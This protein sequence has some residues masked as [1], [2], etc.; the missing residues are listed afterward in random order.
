MKQNKT[1]F[2]ILI[3]CIGNPL[4]RR[5]GNL[6]LLSFVAAL[7]FTLVYPV[8]DLLI[9]KIGYYLEKE[10]YST[11]KYAVGVSLVVLLAW[12]LHQMGG[13]RIRDFYTFR[14][15][16]SIWKLAIITAVVWL[17]FVNKFIIGYEYSITG[18][19][20]IIL[21]VLALLPFIN[22]P[23]ARILYLRSKFVSHR[24]SLGK[25]TLQQKNMEDSESFDE[26]IGWL[27]EEKPIEKPAEDRFGMAVVA[28]RVARILREK[29]LKTIGLIGSYGCGKSSILNMVE[30]YIK[31]PPQG[32]NK[33]LFDQNKIIICK[34]DGWGLCKDSAAEVILRKTVAELSKYVD[35]LGL[36]NIPQEYQKALSDAGSWW[37]KLISIGFK[38]KDAAKQLEKLDNVLLRTGMR[39]IIFI[40]D[41]DRNVQKDEKINEVAALLDRLKGLENVSFVLAISSNVNMADAGISMRLAEHIEVIPELPP[42]FVRTIIGTFRKNRLSQYPDDIDCVSKD[43]RDKQW[44]PE[45]ILP[46]DLDVLHSETGGRDR[47]VF[48]IPKLL[49]GPRL[50][51]QSL[52]RTWQAWQN[53]RGE[54]DFDDLLMVNVLRF[55][56]PEAFDFVHNYIYKLR[57]AEGGKI[58]NVIEKRVGAAC[59]SMNMGGKSDSGPDMKVLWDNNVKDI[60]W[61]IA[62]AYNLIE[63]IFPGITNWDTNKTLG[64]QCIGRES[65]S[66]DYWVRLN[67]EEL[68]NN[69]IQDQQILL[70]IDKWKQ[71]KESNVHQ[72]HTLAEA[73]LNVEGFAEK[74]EQFGCQLNGQ[75]LKELAQQYFDLIRDEAKQS[76]NINHSEKGTD[77]GFLALSNLI[78]KYGGKDL[79][80]EWVKDEIANTLPVSLELANDIHR[81]YYEVFYRLSQKPQEHMNYIVKKAEEIYED[82]PTFVKVL[83]QAER[84]CIFR[85]INYWNKLEN[86][87]IDFSQWSWLGNVLLRAAEENPLVIIP[88]IVHFVVKQKEYDT[89]GRPEKLHDDN[90]SIW[91]MFEGDKR[92]VMELL[93]GQEIDITCFSEEDRNIIQFAQDKARA[94]LS[95]HNNN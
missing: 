31:N 43:E 63:A 9:E 24:D 89:G 23:I 14:L 3:R 47:P 79:D 83:E 65:N 67:A 32:N 25:L 82:I 51:K 76:K 28:R 69:E 10:F 74:V 19:G 21:I 41:V 77:S 22:Y 2:D 33:E 70:A 84:D 30:H 5:I 20:W 7:I 11:V 37:L 44:G 46:F 64:P 60:T 1:K 26:L 18:L 53:L 4:I 78:V 68:S 94:W 86:N 36:R 72:E 61:N 62:A 50:L 90:T 92:K 48:A 29:P 42:K 87:K 13:I 39:M 85:F 34:I 81:F 55:A 54:I 59:E 27:D 75:Q 12:A 40:E 16:L 91:T 66:T 93:S 45:S 52:R 17:F 35:C 38:K 58:S 49:T 80:G 8:Y 6:V 57:I 56:A 95:Q 88:Q 71:D 15:W 73:M